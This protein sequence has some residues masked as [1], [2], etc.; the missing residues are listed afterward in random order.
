M[1]HHV[2]E[3]ISLSFNC[4]FSITNNSSAA[5]I[6]S[7]NILDIPHTVYNTLS[8]E[9]KNKSLWREKRTH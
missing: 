5:E 8:S 2:E 9:L 1:F 7:Q 3:H 6:L 4:N